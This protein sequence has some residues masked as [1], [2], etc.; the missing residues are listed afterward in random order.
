MENVAYPIQTHSNNVVDISSGGEYPDADG[1]ITCNQS[2]FLSIQVADCVPIFIYDFKTG[3][4][5]L[6]HSGWK[7]TANKIISDLSKALSNDSVA[8]A[9]SGIFTPGRKRVFSLWLFK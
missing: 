8:I 5:G 3:C 6:V 2:V 7:G 9:F 4:K 1:L